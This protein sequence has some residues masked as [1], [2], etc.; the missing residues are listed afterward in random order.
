M[1]LMCM[2]SV[3]FYIFLQYIYILIAVINLLHFLPSC[4]YILDLTPLQ[5]SHI[6]RRIR[7]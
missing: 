6:L 3:L 5:V 1:H 2:T 7:L 4:Q